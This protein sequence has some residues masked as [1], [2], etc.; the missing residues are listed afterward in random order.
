MDADQI[1]VMEHGRI[2]EHGTH[3]GLLAAGG[4]YA[5][6]WALQQ[7]ER[8]VAEGARLGQSAVLAARG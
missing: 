1:L 5:S 3:R 2:V 6:M 7:N 8:E 4:A